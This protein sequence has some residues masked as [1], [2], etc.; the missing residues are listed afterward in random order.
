MK[1]L[2]D[3]NLSYRIVKKI[4]HIFP[5]SLHVERT[6]LP[7]PASDSE[8]FDWAKANNYVLLLTRD[9]DFMQIL[10]LKGFPPKVIMLR[11]ANRSSAVVANLLEKHQQAIFEL[12]EDEEQGILEIFEV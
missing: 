7:I 9:E 5:E 10:E 3:A 11:I 8:I 6:G 12:L 4:K 1:L 2:I